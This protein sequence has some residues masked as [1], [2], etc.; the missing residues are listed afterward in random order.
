MAPIKSAWE[1][2]LENTKDIEGS[3]ETLA[4]NTA[5]DEGRKLAAKALDDP[6][7]GLK[8]ALKSVERDRIALVREGLIQSLLA[9]LVLPFDLEALER[10]YAPK[11]KKKEEEMSR[12]LGQRVKINPA[13]DPEFQAMLRNYLSQL[14]L[15]YDEVLANAKEEIRQLFAKSPA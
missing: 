6:S 4:A 12:Q 7:F 11:L 14:D 2:A 15:K 3:K 13:Q 5:R 10:Q 1:V 9:N 8:E